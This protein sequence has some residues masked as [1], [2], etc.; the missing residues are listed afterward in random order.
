MKNKPKMLIVIT[1]FDKKDENL[2]DV[3]PIKNCTLKDIEE[4]LLKAYPNEKHIEKDEYGNEYLSGNYTITPK[5]KNLIFRKFN[6]EIDIEK[7]HCFLEEEYQSNIKV[8]DQYGKP[9]DIDT[10]KITLPNTSYNGAVK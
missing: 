8:L 9:K 1:Y 4:I 10:S 6:I 7:F 5:I 2:I 3:L